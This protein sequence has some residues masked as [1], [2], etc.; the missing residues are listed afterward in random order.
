ML[1]VWVAQR[2]VL[3]INPGGGSASVYSPRTLVAMLLKCNVTAKMV[4]S[5]QVFCGKKEE[6][7]IYVLRKPISNGLLGVSGLMANQYRVD[8]PGSRSI[9]NSLIH[10]IVYRRLRATHWNEME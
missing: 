9:P 1:L 5:I 4:A 8:G 6:I 10:L 3:I 2:T 7:N